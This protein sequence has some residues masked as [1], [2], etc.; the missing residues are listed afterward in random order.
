MK[1]PTVAWRHLFSF[2]PANASHHV[3]EAIHREVSWKLFRRFFLV[4][5]LTWIQNPFYHQQD[6]VS[7]HFFPSWST[8]QPPGIRHHS[9]WPYRLFWQDRTRSEVRSNSAMAILDE[10]DGT[11]VQEKHPAHCFSTCFVPLIPRIHH[12]PS[13]PYRLLARPDELG[14]AFQRDHGCSEWMRW[15]GSTRKRFSLLHFNT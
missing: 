14:G 5:S 2:V 10:C 7:F 6:F 15:H 1:L 3:W 12:Y 13:R 4:P 8:S 11:E 9:S